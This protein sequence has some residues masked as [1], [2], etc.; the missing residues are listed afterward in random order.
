MKAVWFLVVSF[1]ANGLEWS[2]EG[3]GRSTFPHGVWTLGQIL[4]SAIVKREE[5]SSRVDSL[6]N[7]TQASL[8]L[9]STLSSSAS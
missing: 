5:R 3:R 7:M 9:S 1:L 4:S 8:T 6:Q 2:G